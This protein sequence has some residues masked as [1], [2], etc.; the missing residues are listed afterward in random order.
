MLDWQFYGAN[1]GGHHLT[2]VLLHAVT[3]IL[4]FLVLYKMTA[5]LWRSAFVAAVF[6]IHPLRVESVAWVTERKD[7]LCG[8][9][10][11]LTLWAYWGYVRRPRSLLRYLSAL[12][13]FALGLMSKPMRGDAAV[14]LIVAG[15]LAVKAVGVCQ[16]LSVNRGQGQ[17]AV[18]TVAHNA[19][20][21]FKF[22]LAH[23]KR[24]PSC[25][26][27]W[28]RASR[29]FLPSGRTSRRGKIIHSLREL[30]IQRFLCVTYICQLFYP[31][32]LAVLYPFPY[33]GLPLLEVAGALA[34]LIV[35]SLAVFI[36]GKNILIF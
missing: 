18:G 22:Q 33:Q 26:F 36:G 34:F 7:V 24:S 20:L 13:L 30:K 10:F 27:P 12:L 21:M 8:V 6:A 23:S 35:V 2:N 25:C 32:R 15:L 11:M 3:A 4:L 14:Y 19:T 16:R 1:A 29:R 17:P 31:V 5:A 9:F 28:L